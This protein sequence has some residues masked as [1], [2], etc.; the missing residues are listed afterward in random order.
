[1]HT[2][3]TMRAVWVTNRGRPCQ[4]P[5]T[6]GCIALPAASGIY[7]DPVMIDPKPTAKKP[8]SASDANIPRKERTSLCMQKISQLS[9]RI[10]HAVVNKI[11]HI[12]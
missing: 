2:I 12:N 10:T 9:K 11:P 5:V 4:S 6:R 7:N 8:I 1:M 3:P